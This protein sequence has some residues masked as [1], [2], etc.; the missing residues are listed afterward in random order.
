MAEENKYAGAV[1]QYR[2]A[3]A[4][5][6]GLAEVQYHLGLVLEREGNLQ[7]AIP[8]F[9]EAVRLQPDWP[10]LLQGVAWFFATCPDP[11][12]RNPEEAISLSEHA[13]RLTHYLNPGILDSLAASYAAAGQ[14]EEAVSTANTAMELAHK[15]HNSSLVSK[16][17]KRLNLYKKEQPLPKRALP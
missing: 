16:I 8:H 15:A 2:Q 1:R 3:L 7:Q 13:A 6:P 10:E 12:I 14:F 4:I 5:D 11:G 17:Q 9:R